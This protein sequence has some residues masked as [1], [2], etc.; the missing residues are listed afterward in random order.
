MAIL[1]WIIFGLIIG[2]IARLIRPS[3]PGGWIVSIII[4]IVGAIL[5]GWI[6]NLIGWGG[7]GAW[8]LKGFILAIVGAIII[9]AIYH[10]I[11][12]KKS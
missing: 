12:G 11:V 9:L 6:G 7:S 2:A 1:S 3:V 10:A 5:G 4:G 8:T